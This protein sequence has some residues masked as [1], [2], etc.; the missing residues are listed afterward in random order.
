VRMQM[1]AGGL[2]GA[3]L[4]RAVATKLENWRSK[5]EVKHTIYDALVF[6]KIRNLLGGRLQFLCSGAA[7]LTADVHEMLKICFS[8]SVVQGYGLTETIG[9]CTKGVP[10]DT[11][12][13]GTV[14]SVQPCNDLK[15]VDVAEMAYTSRDV[16]NPRG[17]VCLKGVNIAPGY[18]HDAENTAKAID[19]DG[20]F[21]TG[22]IGE[23]DAA[24]RL[25]IIDRIKNV[26]KLSQG[27]YVAL[28]KV[29]AL[30]SLDPLF[31]TLLVHGDS[32]RSHLIALAVLDPVQAANL[33]ESVLARKLTPGDIDALEKAVQDKRVRQAVLQ[34]L[35]KVAKKNRLNGFEMIKGVHL[36]LTPFPDEMI[37]PT[38]KVKR[39]VAANLYKHVIDQLYL[40]SET[41][42]ELAQAKL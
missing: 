35:A 25:K 16:P 27:E 5:G 41:G 38:L 18:L 30:Y 11:G 26:V 1:E 13:L 12:S 20:W 29:E 6:R 3:L 24:G 15:L 10:W 42:S 9:T 33:C 28:E 2:K 36:T 40:E 21:H 32:T 22:D 8:C 4:T 23:V 19:K 34:S 14:G 39:N 37:T 17:E 31:A 7:P